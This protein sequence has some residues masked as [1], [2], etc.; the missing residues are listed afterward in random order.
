MK[1]KM[2]L[3]TVLTPISS[4]PFIP[5]A[6]NTKYRIASHVAQR[7]TVG[8]TYTKNRLKMKCYFSMPRHAHCIRPV[9]LCS[10]S[11]KIMKFSLDL[12]NMMSW[13]TDTGWVHPQWIPISLLYWMFD[14][15]DSSRYFKKKLQQQKTPS[16]ISF[17]Q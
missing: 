6:V 4:I 10:S 3:F 1:V 13:I 2:L 16:R 5:S 14:F 9:C 15:V 8:Q 17:V 7:G 12:I 11:W